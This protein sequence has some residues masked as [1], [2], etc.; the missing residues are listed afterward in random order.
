MAVPDAQIAM[1]GV[2]HKPLPAVAAQVTTLGPDGFHRVPR[3]VSAAP[4]R[5]QRLRSSGDRIGRTTKG[6]LGW[7]GIERAPH[8]LPLAAVNDYQ[9]TIRDAAVTNH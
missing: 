3:T 4:A 2:F 6:G 5:L 1:L 9:F 7:Q 8:V